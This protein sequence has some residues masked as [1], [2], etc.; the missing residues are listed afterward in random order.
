[1]VM[2]ASSSKNRWQSGLP[3]GLPSPLPLRSFANSLTT[4][5]K[6]TFSDMTYSNE[7]PPPPPQGESAAEKALRLEHEQLARKKRCVFIYMRL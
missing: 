4:R 1:M 6:P 5:D 7:W 2:A 3:A